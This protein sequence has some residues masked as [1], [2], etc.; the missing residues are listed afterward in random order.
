VLGVLFV[1]PIGGADMPVVI[2]LLN[3]FTGLSPRRRRLRARQHV[4]IVAGMLV[5]ASGTILT[6]LMAKAMNRSIA[7]VLFGAF[8]GGDRGGRRRRGGPERP[9]SLDQ[10][11]GRRDPARLRATVV[12]VPGY[13]MAV[14]QAQHAVRELAT[15]SR[16]GRRGEVRDPPGRRAGCPGT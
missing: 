5:G 13:G 16:R 7:N 4:L 12:I 14:A 15:C 3:A 8:G 9:P 2:S 6:Q 10:R 1:L 11:R